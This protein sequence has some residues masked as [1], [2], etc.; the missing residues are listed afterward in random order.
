MCVNPNDPVFYV[1]VYLDPR[2]PGKYIY[3]EY[4]FDYE[5]FYI[6]KGSNDRL[7]VHLKG[8]KDND[9]FDNKIKKIR[10]TCKCDPFIILYKEHL[11]EQDSFSLEMVMIAIIGRSNL[12]RGPLCN[13][14]DGGDGVI[15]N[16]ISIETKKKMSL[17]KIGKKR[18]NE[19]KEKIR[20]S[21]IGK[22]MNDDT[23]KK[24]HDSNYGQIPWNKGK[25]GYKHS[26]PMTEEHKR[27]ISKAKKGTIPW[28]KQVK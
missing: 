21:H 9:Y 5:P 1:Y 27:N 8:N 18:T 25:T 6:G 15:G 12:K 14:T 23:K 11:K 17:A 4:E 2:K 19:T 16:V 3:G 20:Q 10:K 7:T 24:I 13:L 26:K 22:T 28:N